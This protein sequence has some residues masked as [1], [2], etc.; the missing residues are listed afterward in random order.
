MNDRT[1]KMLKG[2]T[3]ADKGSKLITHE[4]Y[5]IEIET[6]EIEMIGR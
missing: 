6:M 1:F 3:N 5:I 4:Q 2:I